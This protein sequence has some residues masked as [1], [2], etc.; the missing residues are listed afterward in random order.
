MFTHR[1]PRQVVHDEPHV[2]VGLRPSRADLGVLDELTER[3]R[4]PNRSALLAAALN[5]YLPSI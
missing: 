5:L 2:Q 1:A 4:A 3:Y